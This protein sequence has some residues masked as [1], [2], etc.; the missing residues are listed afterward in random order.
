MYILYVILTQHN[1]T[2]IGQDRH[3]LRYRFHQTLQLLQ[4]EGRIKSLA[5][6]YTQKTL[7]DRKLWFEHNSI[8]SY[9]YIREYRFLL[10]HI[11]SIL[12]YIC[13]YLNFNFIK[14][15]KD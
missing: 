14:I 13:K 8:E 5:T 9:S 10:L 4:G 6:N 11:I 15:I 12:I 7:S 1:S 3:L 2:P